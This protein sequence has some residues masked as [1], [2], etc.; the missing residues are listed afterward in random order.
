MTFREESWLASRAYENSMTLNIRI[1]CTVKLGIA[2]NLLHIAIVYWYFISSVLQIPTLSVGLHFVMVN[3]EKELCSSTNETLVDPRQRT[4]S[5]VLL[6][7]MH[8][9]D[10]MGQFWRICSTTL[11]WKVIILKD[12]INYGRN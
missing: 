10:N 9:S 5:A 8:R 11:R 3:Y 12:N 4:V 6:L 1:R 2:W 7:S